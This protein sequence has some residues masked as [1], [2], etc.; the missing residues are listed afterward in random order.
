MQ[1]LSSAHAA[2]AFLKATFRNCLEA[3]SDWDGSGGEATVE[4]HDRHVPISTALRLCDSDEKVPRSDIRA[5]RNM[6][7]LV[8]EGDNYRS[9]SRML[10]WAVRSILLEV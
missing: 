1:E 3:L 6:G 10:R 4:L 5:L 9:V 8:S 2:P 7:I